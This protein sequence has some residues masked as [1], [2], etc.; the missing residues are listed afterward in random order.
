MLPFSHSIK[1]IQAQELLSVNIQ[2]ACK[3]ATFI[4]HFAPSSK[5]M[6]TTTRIF[7]NFAYKALQK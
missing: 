7:H 6:T 2:A 5:N 4:L 3:S 1:K